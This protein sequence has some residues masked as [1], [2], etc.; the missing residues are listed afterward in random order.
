MQRAERSCW[1]R[2]GSCA[3]GGAGTVECCMRDSNGLGC[4]CAEYLPGQQLQLRG[5]LCSFV[6][7]CFQNCLV[8]AVC[9][10]QA[11]RARHC[12]ACHRLQAIMPRIIRQNKGHILKHAKRSNQSCMQFWGAAQ[13]LL[14]AT[15]QPCRC[16]N[17]RTHQQRTFVLCGCPRAGHVNTSSVCSAPVGAVSVCSLLD[18]RSHCQLPLIH[19]PA[20][21]GPPCGRA[22][23]RQRPPGQGAAAAPCHRHALHAVT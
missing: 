13:G 5:G 6:Y 17:A 22:N 1:F 8:T 9:L 7:G 12:L 11:L 19:F 4:G 14:P 23:R 20:A 2:G 3:V 15:T 10:H 18:S 16:M 21:A